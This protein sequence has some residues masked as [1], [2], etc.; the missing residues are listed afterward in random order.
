MQVSEVT[1][2]YLVQFFAVVLFESL[3]ADDFTPAKSIMH[4]SFTYYTMSV[5]SSSS[6]LAFKS[7]NN[8]QDKLYVYQCLT[9]QPIWKCMRFWTSSFFLS[10]QFEIARSYTG[11]ES[12]SECALIHKNIAFGQ[13][14]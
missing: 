11:S 2:Y 14:G 13:L 1:F 8:N 4:M 5:I 6:F 3:E 10:M 12:N 7:C 9:D